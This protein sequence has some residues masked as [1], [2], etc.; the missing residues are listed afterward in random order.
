VPK[1]KE[2]KLK[3]PNIER[4][5]K[6]PEC[7]CVVIRENVFVP[8]L[9]KQLLSKANKNEMKFFVFFFSFEDLSRKEKKPFACSKKT[10][11]SAIFQR[12]K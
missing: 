5:R 11:R 1:N 8:F 10:N 7:A 4:R 2:E 9:H 6:T 3:R 12:R